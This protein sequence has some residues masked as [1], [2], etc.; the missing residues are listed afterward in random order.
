MRAKELASMSIEDLKAKLRELRLELMKANAQIATR[1]TPKN[2]GKV[3][4]IKKSIARI[5]YVLDNKEVGK[6]HE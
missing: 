5:L 2:P 3:R 1:T 6:K 4:E